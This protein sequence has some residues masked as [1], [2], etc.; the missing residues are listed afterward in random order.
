MTEGYKATPELLEFIQEGLKQEYFCFEDT[1]IDSMKPLFIETMKKNATGQWNP[2]NPYSL[3]G[4][5]DNIVTDDYTICKFNTADN[6]IRLEKHLQDEF[7]RQKLKQYNWLVDDQPV[8]IEYKINR[9]GFRC[10]NFTNDPGIIFLGCSF[11]YGTGMHLKDIWPSLVAS[12][13][14]LQP[15]NLGTPGMSLTM[16]T[17]YLTNWYKDIPNPKAIVILEPPPDRIELYQL[18]ENYCQVDI[19]KFLLDN[20]QQNVLVNRLYNTLPFTTAINYRLNIQALKLL[21]KHWNI[22][23]VSATLFESSSMHISQKGETEFARD[24]MH[25]GKNFHTAIAEYM[26]DKLKSQGL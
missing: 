25:F 19:L 21:A 5:E 20:Y 2:W 22:P 23:I 1:N 24:L 13:F 11:T 8:E 15:W 14:N 18:R 26:I 17:F 16:G 7:A 6:K 12:H 9:Y 10:N 3:E 4:A